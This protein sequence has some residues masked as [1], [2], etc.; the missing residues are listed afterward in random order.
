MG[1][2]ACVRMD[3]AL[4]WER[5]WLR[6]ECKHIRNFITFTSHQYVLIFAFYVLLQNTL[7]HMFLFQYFFFLFP[8]CMRE[9]G[10]EREIFIVHVLLASASRATLMNP[11]DFNFNRILVCLRVCCFFALYFCSNLSCY[12]HLFSH[13]FRFDIR[14]IYGR[15]WKKQQSNSNMSVCQGTTTTKKQMCLFWVR[16]KNR[17]SNKKNKVRKVTFC[18][19]YKSSNEQVVDMRWKT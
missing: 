1:M 11:H 12:L 5:K 2:F 13:R 17:R 4:G 8:D 9:C 7:A 10:W 15:E 14:L 16:K 3:E 19:F 18:H 6:N